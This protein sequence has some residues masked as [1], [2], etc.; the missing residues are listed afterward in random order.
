MLYKD[1]T[2]PW[3]KMY[4][5]NMRNHEAS[6]QMFGTALLIHLVAGSMHHRR[7]DFHK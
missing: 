1:N 5:L 3:S 7:T 4:T 6:K 2:G